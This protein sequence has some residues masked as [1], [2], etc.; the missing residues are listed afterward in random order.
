MPAPFSRDDETNDRR[1]YE[2]PRFVVHIDRGAIAAIADL[3]R[4]LLAPGARILDLM[5]SWRSH[6]PP[7]IP[8]HAVGLGLNSAEMHD[9]PQLRA[10]VIA[11]LNQTPVLPFATGV[12][13]S[14]VCAV[15]VQYLT[16]PIAVFR[17][18]RRV[19]RH[20]GPLAITFSNRM[21]PTKAVAIWRWTG[22]DQHIAIV[23][24]YVMEAGFEHIHAQVRT[25]GAKAQDAQ[26]PLY[27]IVAHA[28][29]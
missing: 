29:E 27:A 17:E 16:H 1:F 18:A 9:N 23:R 26:D 6:L 10:A 2:W 4:E 20:G 22:D 24:R 15:S 14:V 3:Y 12:F 21:F 28:P 11:D 8:L 7:E 13:D 19:L 5:S 25:E